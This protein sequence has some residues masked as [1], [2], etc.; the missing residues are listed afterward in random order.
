MHVKGVRGYDVPHPVL[1]DHP[2]P[3]LGE[4]TKCSQY[5]HIL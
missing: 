2:L 3:M 5:P 4:G 1:K